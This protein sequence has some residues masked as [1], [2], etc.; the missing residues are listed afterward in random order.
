MGKYDEQIASMRALK[1]KYE[2]DLASAK[3]KMADATPSL[4][5]QSLQFWQSKIDEAD[6]MLQLF[7]DR[8]ARSTE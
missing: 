4:R 7:I 2:A 5:L 8:D 3:I 6:Q 1:A